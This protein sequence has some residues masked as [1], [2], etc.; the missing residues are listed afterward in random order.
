MGA[1]KIFE[2]PGNKENIELLTQLAR[3]KKLV[4]FIGAGFSVPA[5]PTWADFLEQQLTNDK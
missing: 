2:I 1:E 5:C 4:P 3:E